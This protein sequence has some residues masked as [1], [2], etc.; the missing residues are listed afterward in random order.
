MG[1]FK[2]VV[3]LTEQQYAEMYNNKTLDEDTIYTTD[4]EPVYSTYEV[5]AI[6]KKLQDQI[7]S[8]AGGEFTKVT[9]GGEYQP[10][11][12]A[13]TKADVNALSNYMSKPAIDVGGYMVVPRID[14]TGAEGP[15][16][17]SYNPLQYALVAYNTGGIIKINTPTADDHATNKK[18]VDDAINEIDTTKADQTYVDEINQKAVKN[19]TDIADISGQITALSNGFNIVD[20]RINTVEGKIPAQASATNQLADKDFV[21]SSVSTA[22]ATFR[23]TVNSVDS[24]PTTGVDINDYAFVSAT[25]SAGNTLYQRYKYNGSQWVFEYELNNSS[26]TSAQWATINSGLTSGSIPTQLSQLAED[27]T[28]R[29][30][31]DTEKSTWSNKSDFS[32]D[33]NDLSNKP[34]IPNVENLASLEVVNNII[35]NT[36][37]IGDSS[38]GL[39]LGSN[40]SAKESS[41]VA[42]GHGAFSDSQNSTAIGHWATADSGNFGGDTY[43]EYSTAIGGYAN[44]NQHSVAVGKG[45]NAW[46]DSVAI[47]HNAVAAQD[48]ISNIT[49]SAKIV[50]I[51]EGTNSTPNTVQFFGDNVYNHSTHTLT[52]QNISLNGEDINNKFFSGNYN[53]LTNKPEAVDTSNFVQK[54]G[55]TMTGTLIVNSTSSTTP[56]EYFPIEVF[57]TD[58]LFDEEAILAGESVTKTVPG[59]KAGVKTYF[60]C[61]YF[62]GAWD[63]DVLPVDVELPYTVRYY[64][65]DYDNKYTTILINA[66]T[67]DNK[68]T[69]TNTGEYSVGAADVGI[70]IEGVVIKQDAKQDIVTNSISSNIAIASE[71]IATNIK[72]PGVITAQSVSVT[73]SIIV[74]DV[75]IS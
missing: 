1:K 8:S 43:G 46:Q 27:A 2:G 41:S 9:V 49:D 53:D 21:N 44:A 29:T 65:Y 18:Y 26:F 45:S 72:T 7:T 4:Q 19:S 3:Y 16:R 23:G 22:T 33:Y 64:D 52:V 55:D 38:K 47:G 40:P 57:A 67:E 13:D 62:G 24:L 15:I 37:V 39:K 69:F 17:I 12:D 70:V 31:T 11:F 75:T 58:Y 35:N 73:G 25:D 66:P 20:G 48:T 74:P 71:L 51:G 14:H 6:A 56:D 5:D 34:T 54:S 32:G 63:A 50:Q 30:V 42:I 59:V 10:T 61:E 28:H 36:T 60:S 68:I